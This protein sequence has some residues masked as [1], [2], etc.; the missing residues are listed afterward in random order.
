MVE[1]CIYV[2]LGLV[3]ERFMAVLFVTTQI[4]GLIN[5]MPWFERVVV[6]EHISLVSF[7]LEQEVR[8]DAERILENN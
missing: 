6:P 5:T 8:N 4:S 1:S 3:T 7:T 2:T